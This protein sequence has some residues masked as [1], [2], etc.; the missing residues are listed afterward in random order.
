LFYASPELIWDEADY[1]SGATSSWVHL[2]DK[3]EYPRH[4]H[5]PM[6]IYL[7]KL[8]QEILPV[9]ASIEFRVRFFEA[10]VGSFAV[11]FLYW[12]LRYF[13]QTS[14]GAALSGSGLLLFSVIR[15]QETN[16]IGP[17]HL[18]LFCTLAIVVL[19]YHWRKHPTLRAALSLGIVIGFG[20]L[21]MTYVIPA[22]VCWTMAVALAGREWVKW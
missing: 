19:G 2:W 20:A 8:G 9:G 4:N 16:V 14:R 15:L 21:S 13:F 17:H 10:L 5:G 18:M 11:A 7:A 12:A 22:V 3:F 1:V 6:A